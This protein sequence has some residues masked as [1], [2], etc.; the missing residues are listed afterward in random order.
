MRDV[1]TTPVDITPAPRAI[2]VPDLDELADISRRFEHRPASAIVAW[3]YDRFGDDLVLAASFQDCVLIDIVYRTVPD[4]EVA[5]LDTQYHFA[6]TLW[7][8]E[9][10]KARY[11]LNLNVIRPDRAPD[12]LWHNDPDACCRARKVEPMRRALD[13]KAAWMSG[14]RRAESTGTRRGPARELRRQPRPREGQPDR[15]LV[16]QRRRRLR[17]G[18]RPADPPA[19]RARVRLDRL[20]ALH[21]ARRRG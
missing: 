2:E 14:L 4:V 18:P 11:G 15:D 6:E 5:F 17:E 9:Q 3:A 12:D 21:P 7:Y 13:G 19:V 10:V 8:V 1:T 16:R 20:L